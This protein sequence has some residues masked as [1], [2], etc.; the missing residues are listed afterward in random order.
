MG[1]FRSREEV[2]L[3]DP[4]TVVVDPAIAAR[5]PD[6]GVFLMELLSDLH[7]E[8]LRLVSAEI[9]RVR[10]VN[11]SIPRGNLRDI[12]IHDWKNGP[13]THLVWF[14]A[15]DSILFGVW[16]TFGLGRHERR[17]IEAAAQDIAVNQGIPAAATWVALSRP[18]GGLDVD[19]LA[20]QLV[21][22]WNEAADQLRNGDI[23]KSF[24]KWRP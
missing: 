21:A 24:R 16:A 3:V 22:S 10:H 9:D 1:L 17:Q 20:T 6:P 4:D 18:N 7:E 13:L 12:G 15:K 23:I 19:F 11:G 5:L 14:T 2:Q 8:S